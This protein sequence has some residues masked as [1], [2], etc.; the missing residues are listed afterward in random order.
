VVVYTS[1][2]VDPGVFSS[3]SVATSFESLFLSICFS[4]PC[5]DKLPGSCL[6]ETW[7]LPAGCKE[8]ETNWENCAPAGALGVIYGKNVEQGFG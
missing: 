5:S 2:V 8:R 6:P 3:R 7:D 4:L 1:S